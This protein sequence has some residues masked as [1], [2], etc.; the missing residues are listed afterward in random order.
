M[1]TEIQT[2]EREK[3]GE[4]ERETDRLTDEDAISIAGFKNGIWMHEARN[5]GRLLRLEKGKATNSPLY[6]AEGI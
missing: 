1:G 2:Q 3:V 5:L 6:L 4:E